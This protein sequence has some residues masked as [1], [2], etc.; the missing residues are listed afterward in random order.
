METVIKSLIDLAEYLDNNGKAKE[1]LQLDKVANSLVTIKTAQYVGFQGYAVRNSRCWSKCYRHKRTENPNM[2]A[3]EVWMECQQE[4]VESLNNDGSKWDKYASDDRM[5]KSAASSQ[6]DNQ[7]HKEFAGLVSMNIDRGL[8]FPSAVFSSF[9]M[10]KSAD[11]NAFVMNKYAETC[12][13]MVS[14][15]KSDD[16]DIDT[17]IAIA[18]LNNSILKEAQSFFDL[19]RGQAGLNRRAADALKNVAENSIKQI[20]DSFTNM[21]KQIG[22]MQ[23]LMTS[24]QGVL[25]TYKAKNKDATIDANLQKTM[26]QMKA[27]VDELNQIY[28]H[29][30]YMINNVTNSLD[31]AAGNVAT[32]TAFAPTAEMNQIKNIIES[33]PAFGMAL[34]KH[35]YGKGPAP[36]SPAGQK[37]VAYVNGLDADKK[38]ALQDFL[39]S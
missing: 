10:M 33:N 4:Y 37:I 15:M 9:D 30:K 28:A 36:T 5:I 35:I 13:N 38:V 29:L 20:Q 34:M 3:Q 14:I 1:S 16:I 25:A 23:N 21:T 39:R 12:G 32:T 19:F 27:T 8:D 2:P 22:A 24:E 18:K 17:K 11:A 31:N 6:F 7:L 26:L